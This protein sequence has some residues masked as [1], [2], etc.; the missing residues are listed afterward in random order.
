M[1]SQNMF[2][3]SRWWTLSEIIVSR[4]VTIHSTHDSIH[5]F[6]FFFFL[7]EIQDKL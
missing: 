2:F 3:V 4:D 5:V 6:F 7:N 1:Y